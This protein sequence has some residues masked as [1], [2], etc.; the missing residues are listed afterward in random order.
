M[1]ITFPLDGVFSRYGIKTTQFFPEERQS[2]SRTLAGAGV[3]IDYRAPVWK[4]SFTSAV[5]REDDCLELEAELSS[6]R[7]ALNTFYAVDTRR[8]F[9]RLGPQD[10]APYSSAMIS[11]FNLATNRLAFSGLPGGL[12]L[13]RGDK[14]SVVVGSRRLLYAIAEP[15]TAAGG[16]GVT[17]TEVVPQL[18]PQIATGAVSFANPSCEM[19]LV[20]GS[21]QFNPSGNLLAT[22]SF[23]AEQAL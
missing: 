7:G 19:R 1:A 21:V 4:A 3:V 9:P 12:K 18:H 11:N 22:V 8:P 14:L 15:A 13:S 5:M 17:L 10:A 16:G 2:F 20:A 6:L 23:D